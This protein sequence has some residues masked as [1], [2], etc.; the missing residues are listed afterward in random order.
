VHTKNGLFSW[1]AEVKLKIKN[2]LAN[3]QSESRGNEITDPGE[4]EK[5]LRSPEEPASKFADFKS[6]F[7]FK[8]KE[9]FLQPDA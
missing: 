4:N 8:R 5:K 1:N 6:K 3:L 2:G 9:N 7:L